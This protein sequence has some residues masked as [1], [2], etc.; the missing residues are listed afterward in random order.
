[1]PRNCR[2]ESFWAKAAEELNWF[3]KWDRVL[4]DSEAPS[5]SG[6]GMHQS[7]YNCVD[8]HL[9]GPNRNKAAILWEES[10]ARRGC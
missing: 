3:K 5:T 8:R 9:E 4:D 1:M 6:L 10:L 2:P 7:C